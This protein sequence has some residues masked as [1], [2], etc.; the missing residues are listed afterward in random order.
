[1]KRPRL[2]CAPD[3]PCHSE[4]RRERH[5]KCKFPGGDA[6]VAADSMSLPS[7]CSHDKGENDMAKQAKNT[8]CLW[9]TGDAEDAAR[10][11]AK[12]FPNSSVGASHRARE[13]FH[14]GRKGMC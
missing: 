5:K 13:I 6:E 8:I 11:Y 9:Y 12:T 2:Y 4:Q 1:M 10:F 7:G 14:L 3:I